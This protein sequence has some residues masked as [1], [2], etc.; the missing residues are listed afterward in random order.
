MAGQ[1]RSRTTR[2]HG[3]S[4]RDDRLRPVLATASAATSASGTATPANGSAGSTVPQ[5]DLRTRATYRLLLMRGLA[6]DE[7]ANLTA[8]M[9]GI[10]VGEQHWKLKEVNQLLFLRDMQRSGRLGESH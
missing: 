8:F 1:T 9:S 10:H 3:R 6:P 4:S 5:P 2:G 7:A